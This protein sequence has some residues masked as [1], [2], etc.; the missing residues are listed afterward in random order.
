MLLNFSSEKKIPKCDHQ[1]NEGL[2]HY[3]LIVLYSSFRKLGFFYIIMQFLLE[4][5]FVE[6]LGFA[7]RDKILIENLWL[8]RGKEIRKLVKSS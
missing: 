1:S 8:L 4:T 5:A 2:G 3:F 7:I 6:I